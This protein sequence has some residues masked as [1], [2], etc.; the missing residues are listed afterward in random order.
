MTDKPIEDSGRLT[1]HQARVEATTR[2]AHITRASSELGFLRDEGLLQHLGPEME[3][4]VR[5]Y[6]DIIHG[7]EYL[8]EKVTLHQLD[9]DSEED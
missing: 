6:I 8:L 7:A 4:A 5:A 2:L 9:S 1:P 3:D